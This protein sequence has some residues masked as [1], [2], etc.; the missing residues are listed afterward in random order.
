MQKVTFQVKKNFMEKIHLRKCFKHTSDEGFDKST[1]EGKK[2]FKNIC[3]M[4]KNTHSLNHI[5]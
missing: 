3:C 5:N 4:I 1:N 2:R